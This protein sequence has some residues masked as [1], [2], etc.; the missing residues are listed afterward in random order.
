M[1]IMGV[2]Q[3]IIGGIGEGSTYALL[4]LSFV[5]IFGQL[6]ICSVLHGD[7]AILGAYFAFWSFTLWG[8]DP[9]LSFAY[10]L[11][12][13]FVIGYLAQ[14][15]LLKSFMAM[16]TWKGRFQGQIIVTW[17][18]ALIIMALEYIF[19]SGTYRSLTTGYRFL[20]FSVGGL[21]FPITRILAIVACLVIL[22]VVSL[23]LRKT[24]LGNSIRACSFD[25]KTAMLMGIDYRKTCSIAFGIS[26]VI[27]V[28]AGVFFA[29]DHRLSPA[30]GMGLTFKGWAAVIVGGMGS[31]AGAVMAGFILGV[32]E[33]LTAYFWFPALKE[34]GLFG[35]LIAILIFRPG[36]L[37]RGRGER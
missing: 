13:L 1:E 10:S 11:P 4:G 34:V 5:L 16:E 12:A 27:A 21:C 14:K 23:A 20:A 36:G 15:Y 2:L 26:A 31:I 35:V 8:I 19:W 25:R 28:I 24:G 17:G 6:R 37:I 18:L 32:T 3:S 22:F 29:L 33:A 9:F 7:I 30:L